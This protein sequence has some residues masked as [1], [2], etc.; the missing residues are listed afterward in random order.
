MTSTNAVVLFFFTNG[1]QYMSHLRY[2]GGVVHKRQVSRT[3]RL[4]QV[5]LRA[6]VALQNARSW[7]VMPAFADALADA[8]G[9]PL[10]VA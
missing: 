5:G 9:Q 7:H 2:F 10:R 4:F 1:H 8:G 6:W 3:R